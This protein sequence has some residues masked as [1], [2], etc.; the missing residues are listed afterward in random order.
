MLDLA[1]RY[2]EGVERMLDEFRVPWTIVQLGARAEY[3]FTPAFRAAATS[4][5][6][7]ATPLDEYMHL[8]TLNRG[9]S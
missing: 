6:R 1:T 8:Y 3:R 4:R 7:P 2:P 9:S 5:A